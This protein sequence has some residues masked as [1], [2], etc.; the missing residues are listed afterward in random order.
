MTVQSQ[1][2]NLIN[3]LDNEQSNLHGNIGTNMSV[4]SLHFGSLGICM[5]AADA[6]RL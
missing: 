1:L 2:V 6:D 5:P 4:T 3:Y